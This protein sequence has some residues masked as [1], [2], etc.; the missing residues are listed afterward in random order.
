[1]HARLRTGLPPIYENLLPPFFDSAP[2]AEKK[3][4]CASCAMCPPPGPQPPGVQYFLPDAKCC[5]YYPSLPNYL[6]G[7][8]LKDGD[9]S[10]AEGQRRVR[11][12]IA[13]RLD[14]TPYAVVTPRKYRLLFNAAR[15]HAFGRSLLLRCPY[16]IQ[17]GGLCGIWRH[18]EADCSTFFCKYDAGAD[19]ELFWRAL[20]RYLSRVE[21]VL[22]QHALAVVAPELASPDPLPD[23]LTLEELED[24]PPTQACY[25]RLWGQWLGREEELYHRCHDVV[26][27]LDQAA[28]P[29]LLGEEHQGLL[30]RLAAAYRRAS[31]PTLPERL[32]LST[33]LEM[34]PVQGG[35]ITTGY[36]RY[37]PMFLSA[38]L[39]EVLRVLRADE[40]LAAARERLWREHELELPD[41]LLL[42]LHQA[43]ILV[44]P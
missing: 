42:S 29:E 27:A 16:F 20:G 8:L 1:M 19:G 25:A 13:A 36:S 4:S 18:R 17:E 12:R 23:G 24:R 44:E 22:S 35:A 11:A 5:T 33:K 31:A 40:P 30:T 28:L 21:R 9:P 38:P 10:L 41:A 37:E 43:R 3:A 2:P 39:L 15:E 6:V 7:A 34:Q 32:V 26:A 14:L